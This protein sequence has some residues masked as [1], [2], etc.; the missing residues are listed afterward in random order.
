M[1][2]GGRGFHRGTREGRVDK[3][4]CRWEIYTKSLSRLGGV[5]A[6]PY[7]I[8]G[9]FFRRGSVALYALPIDNSQNP[10]IC[11]DGPG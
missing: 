6:L 7:G 4:F 10:V 3:R 9:R 2:F 5:K 8:M 11:L 1:V